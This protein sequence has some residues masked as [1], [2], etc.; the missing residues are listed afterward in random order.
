[1]SSHNESQL[2]H[3]LSANP[4]VDLHAY[5]DNGR[6]CVCNN[7]YAVQKTAIYIDGKKINE[8]TLEPGAIEWFEINFN[9][10]DYAD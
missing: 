3:W 9:Q 4:E 8:I 7:S 1:V 10:I 2:K 6:Y 5:P